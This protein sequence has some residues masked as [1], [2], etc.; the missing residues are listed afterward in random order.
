MLGLGN[1]DINV[2]TA[3]LNT[4]QMGLVWF[5]KRKDPRTVKINKLE[6]CILNVP[7][8]WRI[9]WVSLPMNRKH[10][11]A[12]KKIN[13]KW[14]NLDSKLKEPDIIGSDDDFYDF[15]GKNLKEGTKELFLVVKQS[16]QDDASWRQ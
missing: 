3:A 13:E 2:I 9:G 16:V 11:I 12:F 15:L 4:R 1:Y 8:D 7:N 5:D 6:G 10:W 14:F